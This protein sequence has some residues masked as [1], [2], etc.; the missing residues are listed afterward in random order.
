MNRFNQID[1]VG[2]A[3]IA[4][5]SN[6]DRFDEVDLSD[7]RSIILFSAAIG[8]SG[9]VEA[10]LL[11]EVIENRRWTDLAPDLDSHTRPIPVG[12]SFR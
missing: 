3:I 4:M 8:A 10:H 7:C 5:K 2:T 9:V 11:K 1:L 12:D 6:E